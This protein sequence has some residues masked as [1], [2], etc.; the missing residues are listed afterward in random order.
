[1]STTTWVWVRSKRERERWF[2]T[3]ESGCVRD[4]VEWQDET[5]VNSSNK[6]YLQLEQC[7]RATEGIHRCVNWDPNN[8]HASI[9]FKGGPD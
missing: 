2:L 6:H 4:I 7:I 3:D 8:P 5:Y 1:M 9:N